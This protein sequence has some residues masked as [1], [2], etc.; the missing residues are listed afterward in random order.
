LHL[1]PLAAHASR[2]ISLWEGGTTLSSLPWNRISGALMLPT[3][4]R[5]DR[6]MYTSRS[7]GRGPSKLSRYRDSKSWVSEARASMSATP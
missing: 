3:C 4:V 5:G 1:R 6:W 2:M 7:C